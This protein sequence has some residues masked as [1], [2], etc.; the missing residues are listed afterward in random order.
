[1]TLVTLTSI[2]YKDTTSSWNR[3]TFGGIF[4]TLGSS[5]F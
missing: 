2:G 1:M 3:Q 4:A 5:I